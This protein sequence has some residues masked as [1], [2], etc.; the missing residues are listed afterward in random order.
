MLLCPDDLC[1]LF[2]LVL[3]EIY[4]GWVVGARMQHNDAAVVRIL[5]RVDEAIEV[6]SLGLL[7]EVGVGLV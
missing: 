3:C 1:E 5:N 4:T 2:P 6:E 7:G